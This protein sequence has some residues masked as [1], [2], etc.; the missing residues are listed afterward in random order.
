[1]LENI[2]MLISLVCCIIMLYVIILFMYEERHTAV[3]KIQKTIIYGSII[4]LSLQI[5]AMII[6]AIYFLSN[7]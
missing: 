4:G 1:M 2:V 6:T 5:V 3:T 7:L